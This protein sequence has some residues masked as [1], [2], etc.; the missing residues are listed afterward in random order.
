MR[1][2]ELA[3]KLNKETS[4]ILDVLE[5]LGIEGKKHSSSITQEMV[6]KV[7]AYIKSPPS[8]KSATPKPFEPVR[9]PVIIKTP[10]QIEQEKKLAAEK[11]AALAPKIIKPPEAA[12]PKPETPKAP[13]PPT[14]EAKPPVQTPTV[15]PTPT[16]ESA[17][18]KTSPT[19]AR[20]SPTQTTAKKQPD[21]RP[22]KRPTRTTSPEDRRRGPLRDTLKIPETDI[23]PDTEKPGRVEARK[24]KKK[25]PDGSD[26]V[27][28]ADSKKE[29]VPSRPVKDV[30]VKAGKVDLSAE[31]LEDEP[32]PDPEKVDTQDV[33]KRELQKRKKAKREAEKKTAPAPSAAPQQAQQGRPG[34][35]AKRP[36]SRDRIRREK[37]DRFERAVE[38]E[39]QELERSLRTLRVTE[40]TTVSDVAENLGVAL[41][42][43]IGKLMGMGLMVTKNQRLD[44][45]TIHIIA[46]EYE[47]EVEEVDLVE[48]GFLQDFIDDSPG[49][50]KLRPPVVTVM[51]HV[52]HGKTKL[53]DAIRAT[54]V[55]DGESGGITQHIGAYHVNLPSGQIVF[56]DTPGHETFTAMRAH[57]AMVT[58][59][60]VLVVSATEGVMPQTVEAIHHARAAEVSIIVAVNK[61][62]LPDANPDR[63]KQ[64][65]TEHGLLS[66]E[67]GG[68]TPFIS[69]SALKKT[70]IDTLMES[71][72]L[73]A[74][75][76]EKK[77]YPHRRATG[78]VIESRVDRGLG[79]VATVLIQDGTLKLG[80]PFVCGLYPGKVRALLDDQGR[81]VQEAGP[82]MP[83]EVLG[84]GGVPNSGDLFFV[85]EDEKISR[86]LAIRLQA[87]Q[88]EKEIQKARPITLENLYSRVLEGQLKRLSL[89]VKGDVQ[90]SV[91]A[92]CDG[93]E[94]LSSDKVRLQVIHSAVGP[95][96]VADVMLAAASEALI[97][98]FNVDL[99]PKVAEAAERENVE[100]RLYKII[101]DAINDIRDQMISMLDKQFVEDV[102]GTL[103]VKQVFKASRDSSIFGGVVK[104][105]KFV[106]QA[107]IKIMRAEEVVF[108]GS[109]TSLK[110]FKED[111]KEVP[112]GMECGMSIDGLRD[113]QVGD[114]VQCVERREVQQTL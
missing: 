46:D 49:E 79:S 35:G 32:A 73:E 16:K 83:V 103:E 63:I 58:D 82:S 97:I 75:I 108:S 60:V 37:R 11:A 112:S 66:D 64:Q 28:G 74:E 62:D 80:D 89:I 17:E 93:L 94:K 39:R 95:V 1:V 33:I 41:S 53:L 81:T 113:I 4:D 70:G 9:G 3:K 43:L 92:L 56:L 54:N 65:L 67:W 25:R 42:D 104:S 47:F 109:L 44:A 59:I 48:D 40:L 78:T 7:E 76:L 24:T 91:V 30:K 86:Q 110:R 106:R 27:E 23:P 2:Y 105:G 26:I 21:T 10:E 61:T 50:E 71:I 111:V 38:E 85:L 114:E 90:G 102:I 13:V 107:P 88:R 34:S 52:D 68:K 96:G 19:T 12:P 20:P 72:L 45:D 8:E 77:A 14:S 22:T 31:I 29:R 18:T 69:I 99:N 55:V 51:G 98:G 57:G 5:K 101:Y 15:T 100:V 87:A 6:L 36:K 84:L